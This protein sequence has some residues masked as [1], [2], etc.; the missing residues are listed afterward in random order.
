MSL[1]L[2]SV[3]SAIYA[4]RLEFIIQKLGLFVI[5]LLMTLIS[6]NFNLLSRMMLL[7]FKIEAPKSKPGFSYTRCVCKRRAAKIARRRRSRVHIAVQACSHIRCREEEQ[8][9]RHK[10]R[11][12][13]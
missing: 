6:L 1:G 12:G 4:V 10:E 8:E 13:V 11:I 7:G 2:T 5:H 9:N 3:L